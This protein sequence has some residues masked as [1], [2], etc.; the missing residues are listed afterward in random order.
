MKYSPQSMPA[1]RRTWASGFASVEAAEAAIASI[2]CRRAHRL[3]AEPPGS[4]HPDQLLGPLQ[5]SE[6]AVDDLGE[7]RGGGAAGVETLGQ[8]HQLIPQSSY[9]LDVHVAFGAQLQRS[10][11]AEIGGV[12]GKAIVAVRKKRSGVREVQPERVAQ[13]DELGIRHR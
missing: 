3:E 7:R 2:G 5:T 4:S 1:Q 10:G 8:V 6:D 13:E 11:P 12:V 9:P